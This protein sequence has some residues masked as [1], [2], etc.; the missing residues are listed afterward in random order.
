MRHNLDVVRSASGN[1]SGRLFTDIAVQMINGHNT[2]NPLFMYLPYQLVH[3]PLAAPEESIQKF[4]YINNDH[5]R[6][7]LA[8]TEY[9]M[10]NKKKAG[11]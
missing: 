4:N 9:H 7:T 10:A 3:G 8:G 11:G 2:D 1:Y 6:R 5:G